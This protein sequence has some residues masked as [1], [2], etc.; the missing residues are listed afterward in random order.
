MTISRG[1]VVLVAFPFSSG[2]GAKVR[3]ALVIQNDRN[4]QRLKNTIVVAITST[5]HR[6]HEATQV[7]IEAATPE[8][9]QA[10][11]LFDSVVASDNIATVEQRLIRRKIGTLTSALMK[12]VNGCLQVSLGMP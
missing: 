4:N 6:S 5:T 11:L 9:R 12:Q 3:P 2:V 10:G 1:D 7:L 8:G